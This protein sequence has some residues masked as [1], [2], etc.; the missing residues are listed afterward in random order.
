MSADV[1]ELQ[2]R[3]LIGLTAS[4]A[5]G[6]APCAG[7]QIDKAARTGVRP[8]D[9]QQAAAL[10]AAIRREATDDIM[11]RVAPRTRASDVAD[12]A[13]TFS[14]GDGKPRWEIPTATAG[15]EE[16]QGVTGS[17]GE[18]RAGELQML[19]QVAASYAVNSEAL[20]ARALDAARSSLSAARLEQ[21]VM[22][23]RAVR[24]MAVTLVDRQVSRRL[25]AASASADCGPCGG[26]CT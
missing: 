23:A 3:Y 26:L 14:H 13:A 2:E 24:T 20:V 11:G 16:R 12:E 22:I 18:I 8:V 21:A 15:G 9:L 5:A 10:A 6:C 19:M 7:Y 25:G 1:L 17:D 4:I